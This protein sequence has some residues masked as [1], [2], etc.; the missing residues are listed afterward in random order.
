LPKRD[1]SEQGLCSHRTHRL[2]TA[3]TQTDIYNVK[4]TQSHCRCYSHYHSVI[5]H[6]ITKL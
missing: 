4:C 1:G 3:W 5:H 2:I 6:V